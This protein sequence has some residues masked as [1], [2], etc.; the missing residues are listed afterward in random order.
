MAFPSLKVKANSGPDREPV[1]EGLHYAICTTLVDLGVQ[2]P[3]N[4]NNNASRKVWISF[5]LP[6]VRNKWKDKDGKEHEGPAMVGREFGF[7][8][9]EKSNLRPFLQSWRGADRQFT[10][11]DEQNG[12]D[13]SSIVGKACQLLVTHNTSK[14]NGKTYANAERAL[15]LSDD[16]KAQMKAGTLSGV[17]EGELV[18]FSTEAFDQAVYEKLPQFLRTKIDAR[19]NAQPVKEQPTNHDDFNDDIPFS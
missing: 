7:S 17:P 1:A 16:I 12:F 6:K 8:I 14:A 18:V 2:A 9:G 15:G 3:K 19:I 4:P 5:E 13:I 11:E 10:K